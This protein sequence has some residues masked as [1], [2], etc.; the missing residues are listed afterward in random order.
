MDIGRIIAQRIREATRQEPVRGFR[1][2]EAEWQASTRRAVAEAVNVSANDEPAPGGK[3]GER[4]YG[5]RP[6]GAGQVGD[7]LGLSYGDI[8]AAAT[9]L[10]KNPLAYWCLG[11]TVNHVVGGGVTYR[12][13]VKGKKK[14]KAVQGEEDPNAVKAQEWLDAFWTSHDNAMDFYLRQLVYG[15]YAFGNQFVPVFPAI[16][17]GNGATV[18]DGF[19]KLGYLDPGTFTELVFNAD[20]VRD[21]MAAKFSIN[22]EDRV[23][24]LVHVADEGEHEGKRV[25][26]IPPVNA[27]D[28]KAK[29]A[30]ETGKEYDGAL[31]YWAH[32]RLPNGRF[33]YPLLI[34][35]DDYLKQ[36]DLHFFDLVDRVLALNAFVWWVTLKGSDRTKQKEWLKDQG[37]LGRPP[38]GR[39][40]IVTNENASLQPMSPNLAQADLSTLSKWLLLFILGSAGLPIHWFGEAENTNR[41]S[42]ESMAA[43]TRKRFEGM[44]DDVKWHIEDMLKYV[45]DTAVIQRSLPDLDYVV[46][47]QMPQIAADDTAADMTTLKVC[48]EA[49]TLAVAAKTL[50]TG[51]AIYVYKAV[52]GQLGIDVPEKEAVKAL[53]PEP[54]PKPEVPPVAPQP[55]QSV[56]QP[57]QGDQNVNAK[58]QAQLVAGV[59]AKGV[60]GKLPVEES[61]VQEDDEEDENDVQEEN[62]YHVP[63]GSPAGG[64][65]A[66]ASGGG[67]IAGY[68]QSIKDYEKKIGEIEDQ[69]EARYKVLSRGG[70]SKDE[71]LAMVDQRSRTRPIISAGDSKGDIIRALLDLELST[72]PY[73]H[74]ITS[75][76][77]AIARQRSKEAVEDGL[78]TDAGDE[79]DV[80][81]PDEIKQLP[82]YLQEGIK[83]SV[84]AGRQLM[85]KHLKEA[86]AKIEAGE[87]ENASTP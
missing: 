19:V 35:L 15:L 4:S 38:K 73:E 77:N 62:Q 27:T 21:V 47:V 75:L 45:I 10:E 84:K 17:K 39:E 23:Y 67:Q 28:P 29:W 70:Y 44:Q 42:A 71:L 55:G 40:V 69:R 16:Q 81:L 24:R 46:E 66:K 52:A 74:Q 20:N 87:G 53:E 36:A 82:A 3:P 83:D 68:Q 54:E 1:T 7:L 80:T 37:W 31:L 14:T 76:R 61:L 85:G 2:L 56:V 26:L 49:L 43:P 79:P 18:G 33:G 64:Q 65:F 59:S 22:S 57:E 30:D 25:G 9:R 12:V 51:Q 41:A 32:D 34:R 50:T 60:K 48:A 78:E 11:Q 8:Y 58:K 6:L 5:Y 72:T 63:A 86:M 13:S